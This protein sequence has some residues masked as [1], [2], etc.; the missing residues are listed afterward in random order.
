MERRLRPSNVQKWYEA[1]VQ[2]LPGSGPLT[3]A[4]QTFGGAVRIHPYTSPI[5][6]LDSLKKLAPDDQLAQENGKTLPV[7]GNLFP[8]PSA[9]PIV[10]YVEPGVPPAAGRTSQ[11]H[12]SLCLHGVTPLVG[13]ILGTP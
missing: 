1:D 5:V 2:L 13:G 4:Y 3:G 7:S 8:R 6:S 12:K 9:D 10:P 11:F